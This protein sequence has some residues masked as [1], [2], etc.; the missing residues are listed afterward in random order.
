TQ[1]ELLAY[2][3]TEAGL[4]AQAIPY[5]QRAGQQASSRSAHLEAISHFTTGIELL[6]SLP[7][8]PEHTQHAVTLY[9]ALG[10]ALALTK[11]LAAPEVEHAYTQAHALCQQVGE[12]PQLVP[13]LLGLWGFYFVGSQLHTARELA[14][15]LLRL[16]QHANDPALAARAH[17]ALGS[18]WL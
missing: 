7:E 5:W 14:E 10:A 17:S 13:V 18:T 2:H 9:T 15:T 8:T 4:T 1:P 12:T 3:Y 6:K 16:A 11:G